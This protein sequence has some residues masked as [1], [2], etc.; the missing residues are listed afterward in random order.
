MKLGKQILKRIEK[1]KRQDAKRLS[2]PRKWLRKYRRLRKRLAGNSQSSMGGKGIEMKLIYIAME[3]E[4]RFAKDFVTKFVV[5]K[6]HAPINPFDPPY[7]LLD[8]VPRDKIREVCN[9]YAKRCDELWVFGE[10]TERGIRLSDGVEREIRIA[11]ENSKLIRYHI[12]DKET[13]SITQIKRLGLK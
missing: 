4:L 12:I 13:Q 9:Y 6:G 5:E 3:K 8:T 2:E 1:E 11:E 10:A 7:W